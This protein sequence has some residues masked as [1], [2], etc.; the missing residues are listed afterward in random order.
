[1]PQVDREEF[2]NW[3]KEQTQE[4]CVKIA[5]R[6][7][8]R[9]FPF[10]THIERDDGRVNQLALLTARA[11]LTS[12]VA[13]TMPPP[14]V[15]AAFAAHLDAV[16]A[17]AE[18]AD[19]VAAADA[20]GAA[21]FAAY[22]A[23]Q[24]A[25]A[26]AAQ[27]AH[28]A[29]AKAADAAAQFAHAACQAALA[30]AAL[31]AAD[32]ATAGAAAGADTEIDPAKLLET[33]IWHDPREPD[34]LVSALITFDNLLESG[35]EWSFWREWYQGFLVGKPLDWEL[36]KEVV[37]IENSDWEKGPEHIAGLIEIIRKRRELEAAIAALK[38]QLTVQRATIEQRSHNKPPGLVDE[39]TAVVQQFTIIWDHLE[40]IENEI[41]AGEPSV[42]RLHELLT[43]TLAYAK[44]F[45]IY[46]A[47]LGDAALKKAAEEIGT[48]GAKWVIRISAG[49]FVAQ[50][51]PVQSGLQSVGE[52]LKQL[53]QLF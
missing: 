19:A 3:L 11:I 43:R 51:Q 9:V 10:V 16:A 48:T 5:T 31:A 2:E 27:V 29:A 34:W 39:H 42:G 30:A 37:L 6:A 18:F 33:P 4:T 20:T 7:A 47:S 17:A 38:E 25:H 36:Q 50:T 21:A 22:A 26:A 1:M 15:R 49:Y 13:G 35:L 41:A 28:A 53:I 14:G 32:V 45:A 52:L 46:C 8:L 12:G 23:D 44:A 24:A 40:E